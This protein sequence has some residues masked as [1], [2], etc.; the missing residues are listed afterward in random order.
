VVVKGKIDSERGDPKVLVD[1]I[2]A[3]LDS[4]RP[5]KDISQMTKIREAVDK[6]IS[7]HQDFI[8][9]PS[10][11]DSTELPSLPV[12]EP[13]WEVQ[14]LDTD[15]QNQV[16][17]ESMHEVP[18][19]PLPQDPKVS[20]S[21][22]PEKEPPDILESVDVANPSEESELSIVSSGDLVLADHAISFNLDQVRRNDLHMIIVLLRST[23]DRH[24][25]ALRMRRVHG[26]LTSYPGN[27]RFTFHVFETSRRYH[28]EFP[29]STTGY[30]PELHTQL[31]SLL[32]EGAIQ[33]E[34]L[35]IQ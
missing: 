25:D 14:A 34:P 3:D 4:V 10:D 28:L 15:S 33:I 30:C 31:L 5:L 26:L 7:Q 9:S 22:A 17:L 16:E 29:S 19:D 18:E 27:D 32:G 11:L 20:P 35:R 13:C 6:S 21:A 8:T 12:A 1:M 2:T 24:R 23:G